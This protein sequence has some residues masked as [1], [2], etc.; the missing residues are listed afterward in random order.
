MKLAIA[1]VLF[2]IAGPVVLGS[3]AGIP[4]EPPAALVQGDVGLTSFAASLSFHDAEFVISRSVCDRVEV[5]AAITLGCPFDLRLRILLVRDLVPLRV[6]AELA[7]RRV[8]LLSSLYLGP[9]HLDAARCWG[10]DAGGWCALRLAARADVS[11]VAGARFAAGSVLPM[12]GFSWR[13]SRR[14]S[15][16]FTMLFDESGPA[17]TAG[18]LG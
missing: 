3:P 6:E 9:V 12:V 14:A 15:W 16:S 18:G 13:P 4:T 7:L 10:R 11:F 17:I 1:L 5:A 2:W 8:L